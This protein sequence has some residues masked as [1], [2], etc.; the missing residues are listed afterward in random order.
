MS[1]FTDDALDQSPAAADP[2][3][4][5]DLPLPPGPRGRAA[6]A[7]AAA[8]ARD[9]WFFPEQIRG[10]YG[11]IARLPMPFADLILLSNPEHLAHVN[12]KAADRYQR[13]PM[14]TD[15][16][17][18]QGSPHHASWFDH[19]D[20]EW[21]RGRQLLQPHF[22][23]K[24]LV[25]LGELFTEAIVDEVDGWG[26]AA[27]RSQPFDLTDPLRQLALAVL[28]NAMFSQ[29][30]STE[31]MPTL[32]KNL[33]DR[34]LAT[35]VRTALFSLPAWIPR[36]LHTRG[37][38]ADAWLDDHLAGMLNRRRASSIETTDL[39]NVLI[40]AKYDDGRALEDAKI[41]TEMLFLV[42]GGHETTAAALT[43]AFAFLATRPEIAERV[44]A[45]V[46]ALD[47]KRLGPA[48]MDK[49][50]FVR[51]CFDEAQRLQGGLV[52][53]PKR[54][55]VDDEIGGYRIPAG[56]TVVNS[57]I[58][59]HRDERFWGTDARSY[60]PDRWLDGE[61]QNSAFLTFGRG[62]RMCLG[63]RMAYIEA[64]L[65][66]ATAFQRYR[67]TAKP[68]LKLVHKYRMSVTVKG[69]VPVLLHSR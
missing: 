64:V 11:D 59:L 29:R 65:T 42:I 26:K 54:A 40:G 53:N 4:R 31:L 22:T 12:L 8:F 6:I 51:A 56:A 47:G 10:R 18:A 61:I 43:W 21:A 60:R 13:A 48:D 46:D 2:G 57:N 16:M 15:A 14:T 52:F 34:M 23:Q 7:S 33:D 27:D 49:L 9:P 50:P 32:L 35:T 44:Y 25:E 20:Q 55:L 37:A 5:S 24:A 66:I 67:I 38:R 62:Q 3:A 68:G 45:E 19:D 36:P 69:G 58:S 17:R 1:T 28:Y 41:R 30:I 63:K 39:L